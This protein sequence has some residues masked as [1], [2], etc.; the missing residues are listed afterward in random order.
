MST[1]TPPDED[2]PDLTLLTV[3]KE[4]I[5]A[6]EARTAAALAAAIEELR[7]EF[8]AALAAQA[9][10]AEVHTLRAALSLALCTGAAQAKVG[11][12]LKIAVGRS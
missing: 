10:D 8:A 1:R 7:A 3:V 2:D 9:K 12:P 5:A 6:S 11:S 4:A